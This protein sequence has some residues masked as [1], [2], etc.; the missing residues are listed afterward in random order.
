IARP[1]D[2]DNALQLI[3]QLE[4]FKEKPNPKFLKLA[5]VLLA[6][7]AFVGLW[8]V[9][10]MLEEAE[11]CTCAI[12]EPRVPAGDGM[13]A[14]RAVIQHA[15]DMGL[16]AY[17]ESRQ[18]V[19]LPG[20]G[21]VTPAQKALHDGD[22]EAYDAR[23]HARAEACQTL[24]KGFTEHFAS[25]GFSPSKLDPTATDRFAGLSFSDSYIGEFSRSIKDGWQRIIVGVNDCDADSEYFKCGVRVC[26]GN[27]SVETIFTKVFGDGIRWMDTFF[28][29]PAILERSRA[30]Q[31]PSE[32]AVTNKSQIQELPALVERLT[33]PV[34]DLA[35]NLAGLDELMNVP[36]R[37][38]IGYL[39]HP[40]APK[41]LADEFVSCGRQSCLKPLIVAWLNGNPNF[42]NRVASLREFV[43]T[44]V[45][46]S[47][48]DLERLVT[49]LRTSQV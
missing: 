38:P 46:I 41:N 31:H 27:N 12:W 28:F 7:P 30:D 1:K 2:L 21:T 3:S 5:K 11:N 24:L 19:F 6:D 15:T 8:G 45:D 49:Y 29:C 10:R 40:L 13:P 4:T 36:S 42:E 23:L 48:A 39:P 25:L 44:R 26:I 34:L 47:E 9:D 43:K 37:F 20:G 18:V 14:I 22:F 16:I 35:N 32:F 33:M 17:E